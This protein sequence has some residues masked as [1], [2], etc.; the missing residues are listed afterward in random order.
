MLVVLTRAA[1][2][3]PFSS[4]CSTRVQGRLPRVGLA[5]PVSG[6]ILRM[7]K[8]FLPA[9]R[10]VLSSLLLCYVLTMPHVT[11]VGSDGGALGVTFV[12]VAGK[13]GIRTKTVYG[14][15]HRNRYLLE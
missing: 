9:R 8:L 1:P 10:R 13:A 14:G 4:I 3:R 5:W 6:I 7:K 11:A 12:N 15:E 2:G